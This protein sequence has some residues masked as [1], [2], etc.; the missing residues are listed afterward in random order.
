MCDVVLGHGEHHRSAVR[1]VSYPLI[2]VDLLGK[3]LQFCHLVLVI[4]FYGRLAGNRMEHI[5]QHM[6]LGVM[7]IHTQI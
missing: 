6:G 3:G 4:G 5:V 7:G 1:A 2:V